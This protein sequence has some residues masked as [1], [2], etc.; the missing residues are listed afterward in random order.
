MSDSFKFFTGFLKSPL[1]V[2]SIVPSSRYLSRTLIEGEAFAQAAFVVEVGVGTGAVTQVLLS[3]I[4][5]RKSYLGLDLEAKF[6]E[7][8]TQRFEAVRFVCDSVENLA[9]KLKEL[10]LPRADFVVSGLPWTL[11]PENL[12]MRF[13]CA[14]Q[15]SMTPQG[16][17]V[18]FVY[19]HMLWT[20]Q[21]R[22]FLKRL[23][24]CFL[25]VER[26]PTV[27]ANVPPAVVFRCRN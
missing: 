7:S 25:T 23:Q 16:T 11:L 14:I 3:Q 18:T 17:M 15:Q 1:S 5:D 10:Q 9:R 8:M 2:G 24:Q 12:Q 26:S 27:W 19:A 6:I 21:G 13:L 22:G 20:P 4:R